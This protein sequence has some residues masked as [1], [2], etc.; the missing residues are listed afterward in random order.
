MMPRPRS[1]MIDLVHIGA[2]ALFWHLRDMIET[3]P[4]R[5]AKVLRIPLL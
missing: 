2:A 1:T 3:P 4:L 5:P